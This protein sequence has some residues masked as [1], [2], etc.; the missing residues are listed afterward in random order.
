MTHNGGISKAAFMGKVGL[1]AAKV[2]MR[3][4]T[5]TTHTKRKEGGKEYAVF[6]PQVPTDYS[7]FGDDKVKDNQHIEQGTFNGILDYLYLHPKEPITVHM[8][9]AYFENAPRQIKDCS[10]RENT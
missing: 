4:G 10:E 9:K 5:F 6:D 8:K 1:N 3:T 7:V 2:E